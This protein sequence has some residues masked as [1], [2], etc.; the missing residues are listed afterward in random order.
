LDFFLPKTSH[1]GGL[2]NF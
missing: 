1:T 2:A